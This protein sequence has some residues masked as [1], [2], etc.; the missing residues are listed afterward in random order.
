MGG[1]VRYKLEV[2]CQYFSDKLFLVGGSWTVPTKGGI[3]KRD[4]C[5]HLQEWWRPHAEKWIG[6][7]P[8]ECFWLAR[9]APE[10]APRR[11]CV[12]FECVWAV[13]GPKSTLRSTL[14]VDPSQ[15]AKSTPQ[16]DSPSMPTFA[17]QSASRESPQGSRTEP[18]FCESRFRAPKFANRRFQAIARTLWEYPENLLRSF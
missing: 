15:V 13:R 5:S 7:L 16:L 11:L 14:R 8:E 4:P 17:D 1:V 10:S 9:S 12:L 2:Y 3:Y 6:E 18:L